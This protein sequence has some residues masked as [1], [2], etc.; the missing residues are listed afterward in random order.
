M[1]LFLSDFVGC[2]ADFVVL[3]TTNFGSQFLFCF[4]VDS[5]CYVVFLVLNISYIFQSYVFIFLIRC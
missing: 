3:P 5:S 2:M 4:A 1:L